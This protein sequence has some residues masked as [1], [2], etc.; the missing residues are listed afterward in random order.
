MTAI[1][2]E[3]IRSLLEYDPT[4]GT[5][6][7]KDRG[8]S[9]RFKKS[10]VG[11]VAGS[12]HS[13]GYLAI[14][15]YGQ[16]YLAHHIAWVHFYGSWPD[17]FIDHANLDKHDNRI[18]NLRLATPGENSANASLRCDNTSGFRGVRFEPRRK[19]WIAVLH[20]NG[21]TKQL[22]SFLR[23]EDAAAA[24]AKGALAAF[25][26]FCPDYVREAA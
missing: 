7:W 16:K 1:P 19:K 23:I 15:L 26:D 18:Q 8:R 22:G 20:H 2:A 4:D 24:Y 21:K 13:S 14:S 25:G 5:F 10:M 12:K 6:V 9:A 17:Q 3:V 11:K